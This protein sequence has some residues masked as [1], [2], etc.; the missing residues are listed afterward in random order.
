MVQNTGWMYRVPY[1]QDKKQKLKW[2]CKLIMKNLVKRHLSGLIFCLIISPLLFVSSCV[3]TK[4]GIDESTT[5]TVDRTTDKASRTVK[6]F[7]EGL[8][9]TAVKLVKA[10]DEAIAKIEKESGSWRKTVEET[11]DVVID[12]ANS[13][14][15]NELTNLINDGVAATGIEVRCN[16]DFVGN[17]TKQKLIHMRNQIAVKYK[18]PRRSEA[19]L[20]PGLCQVIPSSID[21]NLPPKRR[22]QLKLAGYDFD[23]DTIMVFLLNG[24]QEIDVTSRLAQTTKY[25]LTLN[26]SPANGIDFSSESNKILIKTI[27]SNKLIS[28]I[29]VIQAADS[30]EKKMKAKTWRMVKGEGECAI[31]YDGF[32]LRW[33]RLKKRLEVE[34]YDLESELEKLN[35]PRSRIGEFQCG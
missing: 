10:L 16:I 24:D 4:V 17:K 7:G 15:R 3:K 28:E 29:N 35:T 13:S 11:R 25:L 8:D 14:I 22:S 9:K 31:T 30:K 23:K 34:G 32:E 12:E 18:I 27:G 5:A 20:E 1:C 19:P 33:N 2:R 26:L 21:L 6:D